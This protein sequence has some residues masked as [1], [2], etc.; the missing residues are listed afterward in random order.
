MRDFAAV[1]LVFGLL[2]K[3]LFTVPASMELPNLFLVLTEVIALSAVPSVFLAMLLV[4][5]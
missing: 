2:G 1:S 3:E 4:F 5:Y